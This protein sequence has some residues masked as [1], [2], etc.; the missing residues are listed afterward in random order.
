MGLTFCDQEAAPVPACAMLVVL[1]VVVVDRRR[2]HSSCSAQATAGR[3]LP[4][5]EVDAFLRPG[6]ADDAA[7][8]R[9]TLDKPP[10]DLAT[11]SHVAREVGAGQPRPCT[12]APSS[13]QERTG[14]GA[15]AT[16]HAHVDVARLRDRRLGRHAPLRAGQGEGKQQCGGSRGSPICCIRASPPASTSTLN[17]TWPVA[18]SISRPTAR[19][20]R[21][22]GI[23]MTIG[24][25]PD[26]IARALPQIKMLMQSLV[27]TD[28]AAI[29]AALHAPG[30]QAEL[31]RADRD[32]AR[33]RALHDVR[34]A[35]SS[36]RSRGVFFRRDAGRAVAGRRR[37]R[38]R[39]SSATSARS[40][41]N[42]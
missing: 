2:A 20:S 12:R 10:A 5:A 26:R 31:L 14:P 17:R 34:C 7:R 21:A 35:R 11:H 3:G 38:R 30:V 9:R 29:D 19:C 39:N 15:T 36:H 23:V 27:G 41:P 4:E 8:W 32:R 24:L 1:L 37:A 13:T 40:P 6:R 16:Y 28:P 18:R 25:E 33:R 22:R 42:A